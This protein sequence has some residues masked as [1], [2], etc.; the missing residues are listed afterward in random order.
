[1]RKHC[2]Q[3]LLA[4]YNFWWRALQ[5]ARLGV[6]ECE[7]CQ[8]WHGR[9][10]LWAGFFVQIG[11]GGL[12]TKGVCVCFAKPHNLGVFVHNGG[13]FILHPFIECFPLATKVLSCYLIQILPDSW[14]EWYLQEEGFGGERSPGDTIFVDVKAPVNQLL[15]VL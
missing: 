12:S 8:H 4:G 10:F 3:D 13:V 6:I 7:A 1:M 5:T 15:L 9:F 2:F 11:G 14:A